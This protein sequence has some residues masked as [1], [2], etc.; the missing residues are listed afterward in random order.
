MAAV[1]RYRF[2]VLVTLGPPVPEGSARRLPNLARALAGYTCCLIQPACR[3]G[4]FP[5]LISRDQEP[6]LPHIEHAMMTI[7][8]ADG[9]AEVLFNTGQRFTIWADGTVG[10][11]VRAEGLVGYGIVSCQTSPL[12]AGLAGDR[13]HR[14]A[15]DPG[16]SH[17]LAAAGAL[18][19]GEGPA[20]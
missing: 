18:P 2:R 14:G 15:A 10:R 7:A 4:Y 12:P 9:E 1:R 17:R 5:A 16:P 19:A 3:Q 6:P 11:T 13:I 20:I 8:L